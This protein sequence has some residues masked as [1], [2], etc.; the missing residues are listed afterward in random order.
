MINLE[1]I[2]QEEKELEEK[3]YGTPEADQ[4]TEAEATSDSQEQEA[5]PAK[6]DESVT[7]TPEPVKDEPV[8][9]TREPGEDWEK[10]Y[11]NLRSSRDMKLQE[12]RRQLTASLETVQVLQQ[13]NDELRDELVKARANKDPLE[14][15]FTPEEEEALGDDTVSLMKKG[16]TKATESAT[17]DMR[18]EL[19][20]EKKR[21]KT[22][23]AENLNRAKEDEY[24]TFIQRIAAVV[25]EW[26]ELN[27]DKGFAQFCHGTLDFDGTLIA[28]NFRVAEENRDATTIARYMIMYKESKATVQQPEN[29]LA[30]EVTPT[31]QA[32]GG[33]TATEEKVEYVTQAEISKFYD[34]FGRGVYKERMQE[35]Q[36]ME[37]RIDKAM[38]EGRVR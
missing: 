5:T 28:D 38:A 20:E 31:G 25:P 14:D 30:E 19:E 2:A 3:V 22:E 15:V 32:T 23:A 16:I 35:A 37:A 13:K 18:K 29:P 12:T 36:Q 17:A 24:D 34:D 27:N 9:S 11:K 26:N 8:V 10:R 1:V 4:T 7:Q 33:S 6:E 21:R